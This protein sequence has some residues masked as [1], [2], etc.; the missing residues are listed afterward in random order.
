MAF[1]NGKQIS[2]IPSQ[3][4]LEL[5]LRAET[6]KRHWGDGD[7][8]GTAQGNPPS[9]RFGGTP[10]IRVNERMCLDCSIAY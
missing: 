3:R 7:G 4:T 5:S 1:T 8:L 2:G 6:E 9:E 10:S